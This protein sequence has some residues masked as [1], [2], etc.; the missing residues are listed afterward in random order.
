M[1]GLMVGNVKTKALPILK[2]FKEQLTVMFVGL[3]FVLLAADSRAAC[4]AIT[5]NEEVNLLFASKAI[6]DH[7]GGKRSS[8]LTALQIR[9]EGYFSRMTVSGVPAFIL[10]GPFSE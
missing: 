3:L 5:P 8:D 4:I 7:A 6:R 1:A 10:S 9:V 2:E